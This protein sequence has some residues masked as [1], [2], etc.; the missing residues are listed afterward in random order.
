IAATARDRRRITALARRA[1]DRRT[2]R[3]GGHVRLE[4]APRLSLERAGEEPAPAEQEPRQPDRLTS[5]PPQV[6]GVLVADDLP[7]AE[8]EARLGHVVHLPPGRA[9]RVPG[10]P[11]RRAGAVVGGDVAELDPQVLAALA[12]HPPHRPRLGPAQPRERRIAER[13]VV[14][15]A[16]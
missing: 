7:V 8:F 14:G 10:L 11:A 9:E 16:A 12:Q 6:E 1:S 5:P 3:A 2:L 4:L 13:D 15:V